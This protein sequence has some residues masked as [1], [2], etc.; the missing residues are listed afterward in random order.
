M[1]TQSV[2]APEVGESP[3]NLVVN[4]LKGFEVCVEMYRF[5]LFGFA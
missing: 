2:I 1:A 3:L 5:S 4:L